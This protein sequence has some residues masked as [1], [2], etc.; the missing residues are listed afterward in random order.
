MEAK[1]ILEQQKQYFQSGATR[2]VGLLKNLLVKL[3]EEILVREHDIYEALHKDFKKSKFEAY[4]GE[5]GIV[6]TEINA[7]IKHID[8]W[9]KPKKVSASGLNFPSR[10]YIY[11]EPYGAVLVIAPW[12]YPFQLAIAPV[13]SA[14]AAGNTVVLKP[15]EHTRSDRGRVGLQGAPRRASRA[16]RTHGAARAA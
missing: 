15:S 7:T 12:N 16:D 1:V 3:R 10:D 9:S 2:N 11:S 5:I 14:I 6:I 8:A 13:I 4:L